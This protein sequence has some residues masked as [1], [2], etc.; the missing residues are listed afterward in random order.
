MLSQK[1]NL[2]IILIITLAVGI[3][4]IPFIFSKITGKPIF[5]KITIGDKMGT[6]DLG[7]PKDINKKIAQPSTVVDNSI[8]FDAE[9]AK[10]GD[11]VGTLEIVKISGNK[12]AQATS[13]SAIVEFKGKLSITGEILYTQP[14]GQMGE[15]VCMNNFDAESQAKL[16]KLSSQSYVELSFCF[17]DTKEAK[18]RLVTDQS[19]RS[20]GIKT[21]MI[22]NYKLLWFPSEVYNTAT[23]LSVVK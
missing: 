21:V 10:I 18:K 17:D 20:Q 14:G 1:G 13:D 19:N 11:K 12:S 6:E 8:K 3:L 9:K 5:S 2:T 4:T 7:D 23:L 16:P 22:D 15:I